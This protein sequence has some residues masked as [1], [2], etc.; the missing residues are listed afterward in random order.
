MSKRGFTLLELLMVVAIIG[1]LAAILLPA[2][3]RAREAARRAS[4]FTSLAQMGMILHMYA[5]EN[6]N[7]FPWSGGNGDATGLLKLIP[8]Y[9]SETYI[10]LCPSGTS[11]RRDFFD[12]DD[13]PDPLNTRLDSPMSLRA[14]YDYFGAYT[15]SPITLPPPNRGIPKMPIMWD[16]FGGQR[17]VSRNMPTPSSNHIPGGGNVLWLDGSVTFE[18]RI[19]WAGPNLP[20]RPTE[21]AF[22][23]PSDIA[24]AAPPTENAVPAP[25]GRAGR[26]GRP[27]RPVASP[28][29]TGPSESGSARLKAL[30]DQRR[31][32]QQNK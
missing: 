26:S 8:D 27:G 1:I 24:I 23:P 12:D 4:C 2:L 9:L 5:N 19:D 32:Q 16:T 13:V 31:R 18:K 6:D 11:V 14:S 10:L 7:E 25:R 15:E 3:A 22:V 28:P 29:R 21:I 30:R 17:R 20:Y